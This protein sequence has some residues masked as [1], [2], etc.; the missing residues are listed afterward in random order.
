MSVFFGYAM[1]GVQTNPLSQA[2]QRFRFGAFDLDLQEGELRKHGIR[3]K[4]QQK[5]LQILGLLLRTP[6]TFVTRAQLAQH[7]WPGLHVRFE[8]SLNTAVNSLRQ[9]L[10]DSPRNPRFI[11]TRPGRGYR[12][13]ATVAPAE[14]AASAPA[15]TSVIESIAVLPFESDGGPAADRAGERIAESLITSLSAL[16]SL[17]VIARSL[18]TRFKSQ[19]IEPH[20]AGQSLHVRAV[21]TGR[22][23]R[24]DTRLFVG[25]ELVDTASGYRL[26]G[27]EYEC[28][29]GDTL[30]I[31]REIVEAIARSLGH[32]TGG[33]VQSQVAKNY[34]ADFPAYQD[35]LKGR[36]FC[37]KMSEEDVRRSIGYFESALQQAPEFA[38]AHAGLADAY[39]SFAFLGITPSKEAHTLSRKFAEKA[40]AIDPALAEA[41]ASAGGVK[42]LYDWDWD[43]ASAQFL[44]AIELNP[45]CAAA[46]Q[47]YAEVLSARGDAL[48]A[49][50]QIRLAQQLD[51]LAPVLD[52]QMA[53]TCYMARDFKRA[54]E[55]SWKALAM[56]PR[57]AAA[58]H[59]LGLAYEQMG[60]HEEAL[61][62]LENARSC[63]DGHPAMIAALGHAFA[64]AGRRDQ[65]MEALGQL[66]GMAERRYVSSYWR[67]IVYCGLGDAEQAL[68]WLDHAAQEHDVW[69]IWLNVEPRLDRL[70][71][72]E[73]FEE[74]LGRFGFN[75]T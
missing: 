36:S 7:L 56:E 66:D 19:D 29:D 13:I 62:E 41:H 23:V 3:I 48:Q 14:E 58:Q 1:S 10:G 50:E 73:R 71:H 21:I 60:M 2:V 54:E 34:A 49:M 17:R 5:P 37:N 33:R 28:T 46:R 55:Q 74:L 8:G 52:M 57:F 65:A 69:L 40:M 42:F 75:R 18:V 22:V 4:L 53:W 44:R 63:S 9:A 47:R 31:E 70:R 45:D 11:E 59:T 72:A 43:G 27:S 15:E 6:G 61:V 39:N 16:G 30:A 68:N 12:F 64:S 20:T 51:P 32:K 35:Y 38:L 26:W 24:R 67:G 25:V